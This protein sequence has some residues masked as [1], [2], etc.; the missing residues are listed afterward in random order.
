MDSGIFESFSSM[1]VSNVTF[2]LGASLGIWFYRLPA[3]G[4]N[5]AQGDPMGSATKG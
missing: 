2:S 4:Q 1:Y 3:K 5:T